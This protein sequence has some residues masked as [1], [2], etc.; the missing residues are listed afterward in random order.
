MRA[1]D[2]AQQH[3]IL[4]TIRDAAGDNAQDTI[5]YED[6]PL[7][8]VLLSKLRQSFVSH[9]TD[10]AINLL[11]ERWEVDFDVDYRYCPH[12][13]NL[14]YSFTGHYLDF[15]LIMS[16]GRGFAA[17]VPPQPNDMTFVFHLD[18]HQP[19]RALKMKHV[20]LGFPVNRNAL[21]IGRSRG[22]DQCYIM[23]APNAFINHPPADDPL[24]Y[25]DP[26]PTKGPVRT[27]LT[28]RHYFMLVMYMAHIYQAH[29]PDSSVYCTDRY[30]NVDEHAWRNVHNVTNIL[31]VPLLLCLPPSFLFLTLSSP[32]FLFFAFSGTGLPAN[33]PIVDCTS[34]TSSFAQGG[35]NGFKILPLN[36]RR[37]DSSPQTHPSALGFVSGKTSW[38]AIPQHWPRIRVRSPRSVSS[39][40]VVPCTLPSQVIYRAYFSTFAIASFITAC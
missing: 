5:R 6:L 35:L 19:H 34:S 28:G 17:F 29:F 11:R 20:D 9:N 7:K 38:S 8:K 39:P 30:P 22:K 13:P 23:M 31:F 3:V 18:L 4:D 33:S 2:A 36:G 26:P 24:T 27:N 16:S 21:F 10:A 37:T 14:A 25:D 40:G 15:L 32:L 1:A 12:D